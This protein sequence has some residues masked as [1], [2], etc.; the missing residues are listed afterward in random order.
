MILGADS[1]SGQVLIRLPFVHRKAVPQLLGMLKHGT[2]IELFLGRVDLKSEPGN[3][4]AEAALVH[5]FTLYSGP[6]MGVGFLQPPDAR[7]APAVFIDI[8]GGSYWGTTC[9]LAR[10]P[11]RRRVVYLQRSR[12]CRSR[13]RWSLRADRVES[14]AVRRAL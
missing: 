8:Q 14:P 2:D 10:S 11:I 9:I 7:H 13:P 1:S 12:I 5:D 4:G 3:F 6:N